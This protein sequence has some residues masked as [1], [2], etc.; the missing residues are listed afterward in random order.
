MHDGETWETLKAR[1]KGLKTE[2]DA[3]MQELGRLN[4]R[5]GT[6]GS[7]SASGGDRL[8]TLD[9][10]IQLVVGLREEVERGLQDLADANEALARVAAT[11]AQAAQAS[12]LRETHTE[13][14]RD[15]KRVATSIEQQ[16][17]HARLIPKARGKGS[18]GG[19]DEAE[20]GL[21][22]ERNALN[23]SLSMVDEVI[24]TATAS[25]DML[26]GQRGTLAGVDS[27]VG[28]LN[29]VFPGIN[30]LINKI[31]D[32]KNTERLVLSGTVAC[33]MAFTVWYKFF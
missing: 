5:L 32:R 19:L 33:C 16:Y 15:F 2:L 26:I 8:A 9:G 4:K 18:G 6:A 31:S 29:S 21:M 13:L 30:G 11:S 14:L 12:R 22:R 10:Q 1:A 17:Q 20:E 25:R 7:S 24:G 23:G 27:K 28:G 3:K